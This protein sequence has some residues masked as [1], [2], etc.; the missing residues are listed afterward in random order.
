MTTK[1]VTITLTEDQYNY[2]IQKTETSPKQPIERH[3]ERAIAL[4]VMPSDKDKNKI[5]KLKAWNK[6]VENNAISKSDLLSYRSAFFSGYNSGWKN[7]QTR[8]DVNP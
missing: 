7:F 2:L 4:Y 3:I 1:T 5:M 6:F 8:H